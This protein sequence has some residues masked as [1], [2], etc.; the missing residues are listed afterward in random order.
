MSQTPGQLVRSVRRRKK[1]SQQRLAELADTTQSAISRLE[2]DE[3]SP[4][5]RQLEKLLDA[6]G[7]RLDLTTEPKR[8]ATGTGFEIFNKGTRGRRRSQS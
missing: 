1:L 6:M 4:T 2:K 7:E 3:I 5:V 8:K